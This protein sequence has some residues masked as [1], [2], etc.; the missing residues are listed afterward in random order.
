LLLI[1][2]GFLSATFSRRH[3]ECSATAASATSYLQSFVSNLW[4]VT[5]RNGWKAPSRPIQKVKLSV[6]SSDSGASVAGKR[7]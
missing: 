3:P 7:K 2:E 1:V 4:D 6:L 5:G